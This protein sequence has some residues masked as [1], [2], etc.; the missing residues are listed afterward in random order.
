MNRHP[1]EDRTLVKRLLA[2]D[3]H[4]FDQF[5]ED[6]FPRLFRFALT[7]LSGDQDQA[8]EV[9][10]AT[11]CHAVRQLASF[12]GEASLFTWLC[13]ICRR[14]IQRSFA[15]HGRLQIA[16]EAYE[17]HPEIRAALESLSREVANPEEALLKDELARL[18][19]LTFDHIRPNHAQVLDMKYLQGL[20]VQEIANRLDLGLK[21]AESLLTRARHSFRDGFISLSQP[22]PTA[23]TTPLRR[24]P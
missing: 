24:N 5:F 23:R 20:P 22:P 8:E 10:Q 1:S 9:V 7:R 12:R 16:L 3:P 11:L 4:S 14:E 17:D 13:T 18:V 6:Y 19:H 21:A 15:K 2:G